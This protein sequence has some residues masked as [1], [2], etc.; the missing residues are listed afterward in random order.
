M[1]GTGAVPGHFGLC[2]VGV[3]ENNKQSKLLQNKENFHWG[4][5]RGKTLSERGLLV[6]GGVV[7]EPAGCCN[8]LRA[9]NQ[10]VLCWRKSQPESYSTRPGIRFQSSIGRPLEYGGRKS[11][12]LSPIRGVIFKID[13]R[14][15]R[16][17]ALEV[18]VTRS[19]R[20]HSFCKK[21]AANRLVRRRYHRRTRSTHNLQE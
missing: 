8:T 20:C 6:Y 15:V 17:P 7:G 16:E 9:L 12:R 1:P 5:V 2:P 13:C 18:A 19:S 11:A 21:P 10:L 14:G 3:L 4:K